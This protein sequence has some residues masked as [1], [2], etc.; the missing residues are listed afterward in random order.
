M[1]QKVT[2]Q[3]IAKETGFSKSQVSRALSGKYGVNEITRTIILAEAVK[4]GYKTKHILTNKSPFSNTVTVYLKRSCLTNGFWGKVV[5]GIESRA[6]KENMRLILVL[7]DD[8]MNEIHYPGPDETSGALV[9]ADAS[10]D[11]L[12]RLASKQL[13]IVLLDVMHTY[14]QFDQVSANNYDGMYLATQHL[15]EKGHRKLLFVGSKTYSYSFLQRYHGCRDCVETFQSLGVSCKYITSGETESSPIRTYNHN[16]LV[17]LFDSGYRPTGIIC[18]NDPTAFEV[19]KFLKERH[20]SVPDDVSLIGFDDVEQ[21]TWMTPKLTTM[22][23]PRAEMGVRA[24]E[25]LF[26]RIREPLRT[27]ENIHMGV[28]LVERESVK[29]LLAL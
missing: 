27:T 3:D 26:Q 4:M 21:C 24:V 13:P 7:M 29:N 14:P 9:V 10:F 16:A 5:E 22:H 20:L 1:P 19:F 17:E 23:V 2:I 25:V 18:V 11:F 8:Y 12:E 6:N 15:I 28:Q